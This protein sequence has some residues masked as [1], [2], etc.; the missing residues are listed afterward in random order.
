MT[1]NGVEQH[2]E[3]ENVAGHQKDTEQQLAKEENFAADAAKEDFSRI[4]HAVDLG[5]AQLKL[6]DDITSVPGNARQAQ[7]EEDGAEPGYVRKRYG[8]K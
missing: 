8:I 3:G 6:A 4:T 2:G 7:D 1:G 5:I